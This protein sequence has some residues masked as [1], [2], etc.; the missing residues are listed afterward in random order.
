MGIKDLALQAKKESN[1][2]LK[3]DRIKRREESLN[4]LTE[5]WADRWRI[6]LDETPPCPARD[7]FKSETLTYGDG[8]GR[9]PT[10]TGWSSRST[11]SSSSTPRIRACA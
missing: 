1:E 9:T 2:Q 7:Q 3:L 5:N 4:E 11:R 10:V 6:R 8:R